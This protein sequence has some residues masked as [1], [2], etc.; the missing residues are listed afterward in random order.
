MRRIATA[1]VLCML[2]IASARPD[3]TPAAAALAI[4]DLRVTAGPTSATVT[5]TT[6]VVAGGVVFY[7]PASGEWT[8]P[9]SDAGDGLSH[10]ASLPDLEPDTAYRFWV[11]A[12]LADGTQAAS[13]QQ[14]FTTRPAAPAAMP[15]P[16]AAATPSAGG[17]SLAA[18]AS[19]D[20]FNRASGLGVW[21]FVNPLGDAGYALTG[22]DLRIVV[23]DGAPHEPWNGAN[24][25]VRLLQPVSNV[26]FDIVAKFNSRVTGHVA[27]QGLI[28]QADN[29][30]YVRFDVSSSR[31]SSGQERIGLFAGQVVSDVG[32]SLANNGNLTAL[33]TV[34]PIYLR[35]T[36]AGTSWS[37]LYSTDG[38]TWTTFTTKTVDKAINDAVSSLGVFAGNAQPGQGRYAQPF[39]ASVDFFQNTA[40]PL[41]DDPSP[42]ADSVAPLIYLPPHVV[43]GTSAA[44]GWFTDEP[45]TAKLEYRSPTAT[46]GTLSAGSA[47][48]QSFVLSGLQPGATYS[49]T[50]TATDAAGHRSSATGVFYIPPAAGPSDPTVDVWYGDSQSFGARGNPQ[51]WVNILG[52][53]SDADGFNTDP[54][55]FGT[56]SWPV[57]YRLNGGPAQSLMIGPGSYADNALN[58][59]RTYN[60]G[61]FNVEIDRAAL[62]PGANSLVISATDTKG[63]TATRTVTVN[64]TAG[65]TWP[66]PYT[67]D[68]SQV[69]ALSSV[70]QPVDGLW[71]LEPDSVRPV[72]RGYD[73]L[74]ALGDVSWGDFE[75]TVPITIHQIDMYSGS[76]PNSGG[77]GVGM[78][79]RWQGHY[80]AASQAL[81]TQPRW[82]YYPLG[83]LGWYRLDRIASGSSVYKPYLHIDTG[84]TSVFA[85]DPALAGLKIGQTYVFKMRVQT[86]AGTG[87]GDLY[88]MKVW[89]ACTSEPAA[90]T[91]V[92]TPA[93]GDQPLAQG[94]LL[95]VA[96]HVDASFGDVWVR[97][98]GG[99]EA[100]PSC[101]TSTPTPT[102]APSSQAVYFPAVTR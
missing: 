82:V 74:L 21:T 67:I 83:G 31:T 23:P 72:E 39:T 75:V 34:N 70:A 73:R 52:K 18:A 99:T 87:G 101:G 43:S 102:P 53:V 5:W 77:P 54:T 97:P 66:I 60:A 36:R 84:A 94:S 63:N 68:W 47:M 50:A 37:F 90:W 13:D 1:L 55:N 81:Q 32:A 16:A 24:N 14:S 58:W 45:T 92:G 95:L 10:T 80:D 20:V 93:A 49:Y 96:H 64:Y 46:G 86:G 35:I 7:G 17:A 29:S 98:V 76:R 44:I 91:V 27:M 2:L 15:T 19:S 88:S 12:Y 79:V 38:A 4:S 61:D 3:D 33:L 26:D 9:A 11:S 41:A 89:P 25:A 42:L 78:I 6:N 30:N 65:K 71:A 22:T 100:L 59:R 28:V 57:S 56:A 69:S 8:E 62:S 51:R 40:A 85:R 48:F